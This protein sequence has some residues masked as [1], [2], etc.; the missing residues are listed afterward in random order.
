MANSTSPIPASPEQ[1]AARPVA[2]LR[3]RNRRSYCSKDKPTCTRCRDGAFDCIY[4]E[5]RKI[6]VNESYLRELEAKVKAYEGLAAPSRHKGVPI[7]RVAAEETRNSNINININGNASINNNDEQFEDDHILL[8]PFAQLSIDQPSTTFK[9]PWASD[10]LLR[11]VRQI[12]GVPGDDGSLDINPNFYD[13]GALPSRRFMLMNQVR[14]PPIDIARRLFAAQYT[15]IGTIFAFTDPNTFDQELLAAYRGLPDLSDKDACLSFAKVLVILAF[16]QLY[17][18][19]QWIDFKGPPGFEYFTHALQL[20]PDAHEEGSILCAEVLALVGY[21]MQN[22]NRRDAAFLYIGMALRMAISLG[23]H[24]EV[25][26]STSPLDISTSHSMSATSSPTPISLSEAAREHRRRVWWSIYSLDRILSVKSGNPITIQDED[27]GVN[28]PAKLPR[29]PQYCPAVVLRHYTE[30]SRIL[31]EIT[32]LIYRRKANNANHTTATKSGRNL[33]ASVQNIMLALSKWN[34]DLPPELR[35][36][37]AKL[38]IS[39]ES[40]STF[41]HYYQCINMTARPLLF[42]VV[43]KRLRSMQAHNDPAVIKE[44]EWKTNLSHTTVRVI[45][46]CLSAAHDTI[47]MMTIAKQRDLVATYGYMDGEHV[48]SATIVLVMVCVAFPT[49]EANTQAMN[50]GLELLKGMAERGNSH[51]GARYHLLVNLRARRSPGAQEGSLST[52][53]PWIDD[54]M[55][56]GISYPKSQGQT[57][58]SSGPAGSNN[59][60]REAVCGLGH[61]QGVVPMFNMSDHRQLGELFYDE[62]MS[63]GTDFMLWEEGYTNPAVDAGFDLSQLTQ[64]GD[65][66]MRGGGGGCLGPVRGNDDENTA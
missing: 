7:P 2:C 37:P 22:M 56:C 4:E 57:V 15:Y 44:Q 36:D 21:F 35:F 54:T 29:E 10:Y 47:T 12:Y 38:S 34:R 16:G 6:A 62:T 53:P 5:A 32:K 1:I 63:N 11:N 52:S 46:H 59:G 50:A 25:S 23:L 19:N 41:S 13:P 45:D 28:L 39:R 18:V 3:C 58:M 40:V 51:M 43:Q 64:A 26:S 24:Q 61:G 49:S 27:I 20:L 60:G 48:F 65:G 33:M 17:S 31:G 9:G 55:D 8:E 30:L 42:H 14:L 66:N